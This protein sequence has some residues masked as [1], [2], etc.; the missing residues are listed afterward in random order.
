[1]YSLTQITVTRPRFRAINHRRIA[2]LALV[3]ENGIIVEPLGL[4]HQMPLA[5]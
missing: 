3:V 5:H 4:R 1:M 2:I